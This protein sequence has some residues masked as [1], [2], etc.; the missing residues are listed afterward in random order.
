M[1]IICQ[2]SDTGFYDLRALL[3]WFIVGS[4]EKINA[5]FWNFPILWIFLYIFQF[6]C[7]L[8]KF[9][10]QWTWAAMTANRDVTLRYK[11]FWG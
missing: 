1:H 4:T 5:I 9:T 2:D 6:F 7:G 8:K 10:P 11:G 3:F